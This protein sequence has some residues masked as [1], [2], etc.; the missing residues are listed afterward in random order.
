MTMTSRHSNERRTAAHATA[1]AAAIFLIAAAVMTTRSLDRLLWSLPHVVANVSQL[2]LLT[3]ATV[4]RPKDVNQ[5]GRAFVIGV[6]GTVSP[7]AVAW[8]GYW[9]P[10]GDIDRSLVLVGQYLNLA[11]MPFYLVAVWTLGSNLTVLPE[12]SSLRTG[13]VYSVSRHPLYATYFFWY[14]VQNLIFQSWGVVAF[15]AFQLAVTA[16]RA[17]MEEQILAEN[18]PE[19]EAY[20]EKVMWLGRRSWLRR[21]AQTIDTA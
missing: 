3:I 13:G 14:V 6:V 4:R 5:G 21:Q 15:S 8:F 17:R 2:I 10:F 20:K 9:L 1:S 16:D 18:F 11:V 12:A 7:V 19:Y